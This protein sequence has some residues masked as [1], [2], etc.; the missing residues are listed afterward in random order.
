MD[1]YILDSRKAYI[2]WINN[3][4][5]SIIKN[6]DENLKIYQKFIK[7]YLALNTPYRG[8]L[9]F[10]GLGTG[11]TATAIS[12]T[13]GLSTQM[14]ITT[15]LPASL[16][17]EFINEV[18]GGSNEFFKVNNNNWIFYTKDEI[19][20]NKSLKESLYKNFI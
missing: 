17:T 15:L 10:H 4:H 19:I 20:S 2:D 1:K 8:L 7:Y 18:K 9:V 3:E 11:K 6:K 16:E 14:E 13:E 12:S 5:P